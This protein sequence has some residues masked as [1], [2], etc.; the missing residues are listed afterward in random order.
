MLVEST[1]WPIQEAAYTPQSCLRSGEWRKKHAILR[2][3]PI[4]FS[5]HFGR[6]TF[7]YRNLCHLQS[8]LQMGSFSETNPI[9]GV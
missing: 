4:L 5:H 3:E 6:I 1:G 9:L 8:D 2:N 7:I